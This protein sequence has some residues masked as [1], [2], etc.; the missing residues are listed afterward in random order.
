MDKAVSFPL[1]SAARENAAISLAP[2]LAPRWSLR[3]LACLPLR[4]YNTLHRLVRPEK[5]VSSKSPELQQVRELAAVPS[6]INEHLEHIFAEALLCRPRLIVELGVRG[7]ISTFVFERAATLC[8]A[9]LV[10]VDI[11]DCSGASH[12]PRW[13]FHRGDDVQFAAQFADFCRYR[14]V[15]PQIDLLFIDTSHYYAHTVEE[16]GAW[17]PH[18]SQRAKVMFH[19]TNMKLT[20][21]RRDGRIQLAWDNQRGVIRAIEEHLG[22]HVDEGSE[23]VEYAD[24]WLLRHVP[25]C[26]GFTILDRL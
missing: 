3:G 16:I 17:F 23:C 20:G 14:N 25:N 8:S 24:G 10:S 9:T 1:E 11:E 5:I 13:H 18:L 21:P 7:G 4:A 22:I 19:D 12:Y 15:V 6:D 26:N 2:A